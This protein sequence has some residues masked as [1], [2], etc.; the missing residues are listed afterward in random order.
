[1]QAFFTLEK[2]DQEDKTQQTE[3]SYQVLDSCKYI[4]KFLTFVAFTG[5][6]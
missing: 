6:N 5:D 3:A 4:L 1:M 2:L